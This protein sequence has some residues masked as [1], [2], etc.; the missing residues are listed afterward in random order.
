MLLLLTKQRTSTAIPTPA[1]IASWTKV[2]RV[3]QKERASLV[4]KII[5]ADNNYQTATNTYPN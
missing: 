1:S 4:F 2:G 3:R 5:I